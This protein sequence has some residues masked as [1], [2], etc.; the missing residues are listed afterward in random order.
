MN[1]LKLTELSETNFTVRKLLLE[2][3]EAGTVVP[4]KVPTSGKFS[5]SPSNT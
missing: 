1:P 4:Q 2:A 3:K 5:L